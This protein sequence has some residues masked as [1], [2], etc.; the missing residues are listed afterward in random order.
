VLLLGLLGIVVIVTVTSRTKGIDT[1][2][3]PA[4]LVT[5]QIFAATSEV[6]LRASPPSG[7]LLSK[8]EKTGTLRPGDKVTIV[9]TRQYSGLLFTD[10]WV[11]VVVEREGA[12]GDNLILGWA[13]FGLDSVSSNFGF[14]NFKGPVGAR[15]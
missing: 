6:P 11:K 14:S 3:A 2:G 7:F 9:A 1:A 13:Y 15:S 5:G 8:G 4:A 12:S 10:T